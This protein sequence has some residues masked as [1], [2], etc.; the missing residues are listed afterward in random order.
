[1][2]K[3]N[4]DGMVSGLEIHKTIESKNKRYDIWVKRVI[5]YADLKQTKDFCTK[6]YESTGGRPFT[7]YEFTLDATKKILLTQRTKE[8]MMLYKYLAELDG[9]FVTYQP[10]TRKEL[11]F[12]INL[13]EILSEITK[14]IPQH[15]ILNYRIDFYLP[16]LNIAIEYD[17]KHHLSRRKI[18]NKRQKEI[19]EILK[20]DFIRV[21]EYLELSAVNKLI[22]LILH[23]SLQEYQFTDSLSKYGEELLNSLN[24]KTHIE[25]ENEKFIEI[26]NK[27]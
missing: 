17:E 7:D 27:K 22:K 6:V 25:I 12:E 20:C 15:P 5:Q 14:I 4:K 10:K 3:I 18:D 24:V 11:L 8:A 16:E 1:M 21:A 2:L 19:Q 9:V 13:I 26:L 23:K